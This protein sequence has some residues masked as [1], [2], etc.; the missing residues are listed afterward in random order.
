MESINID[1]L[2]KM[3]NENPDAPVFVREVLRGQDFGAAA[4]IMSPLTEGRYHYHNNHESVLIG[5]GGE[6]VEIIEGNEFPL[7]VNDII[8]IPPMEKHRMINQ[9]DKEFRYLE[10]HIPAPDRSDSVEVK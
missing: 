4:G 8:Y 5:I 10:F 7:R 6:A 9:K 1:D 3:E 2:R